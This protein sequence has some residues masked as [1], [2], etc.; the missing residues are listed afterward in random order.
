MSIVT[1]LVMILEI[2]ETDIPYHC[3]THVIGRSVAAA[4]SWIQQGLKS[5]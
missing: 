3:Y 4:E 1:E 5:T 2:I